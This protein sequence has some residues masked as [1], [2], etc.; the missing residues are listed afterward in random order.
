MATIIGTISK[1]SDHGWRLR[2]PGTPERAW[3]NCLPE[4]A[5]EWR[6]EPA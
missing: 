1:Y 3:P 2:V 4:E 6:K 5:E